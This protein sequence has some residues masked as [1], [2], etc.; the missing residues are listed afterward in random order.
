MRVA[1]SYISSK[2]N[3]K[4]TIIKINES[5]ADLLHIDLMDGLYVK[6]NNYNYFDLKYIVEN[7]IKDL[8]VHL[9]CI[10]PSKYIKLFNSSNV[11]TIFIH[12][13]SFEEFLKVK[14]KC[15]CNIGIVINP[16]EPVDFY[17]RYL[18]VC[19]SVLV[20][21][22][23]PGAGGQEFID[24]T[25]KMIEDVNAYKKDNILSFDICVDG[26]IND[27]T[28]CKIDSDVVAGVVSGSFVC[29]NDD[30]TAAIDELKKISNS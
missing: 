27:K 21:G 22:V 23:E 26:G 24:N 28:I 15:K 5:S 11:K 9:M 6:K 7:S 20:M 18:S 12:T 2:F 3:F 14:K 17:H 19:Q 30:Y 8:E 16:Q 10:N 25:I 13:T 4:D 29:N 1:V